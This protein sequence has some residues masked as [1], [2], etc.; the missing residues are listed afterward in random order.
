MYCENTDV[1]EFVPASSH[2]IP[3]GNDSRTRDL[4]VLGVLNALVVVLSHFIFFTYGFLGPLAFMLNFFHQSMENLLIASV[5]LMMPVI[6]PR[7]PAFTIN[8][9]VWSVVGLM[10][11]WWPVMMAAIPAGLIADAIAGNGVAKRKRPLLLAYALYTPLLTA[12]TFWPFLFMK[13]SMLVQRMTAM[14]PGMA[15]MV[16]RFTTSF[17][18]VQMACAFITAIIGGY[19]ALRMIERHFGMGRE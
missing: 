9:A 1:K 7:R 14:D 3:S 8:A 18:L 10:Q 2:M 19:A 17:F 6:A 5:Y 11:G 4:I 16:G 12:G 15:D 13:K